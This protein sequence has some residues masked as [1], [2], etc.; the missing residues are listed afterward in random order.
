MMVALII[1][2]LLFVATSVALYFS[3]RRNMQ[4]DDRID[5]FGEQLDQSLDIIDECYGRI[6][7][8][9]ETPLLTDEPV[10]RS[11]MSD[12]K[13]TR[14]AVLLVANKITSFDSTLVDDEVNET[15]DRS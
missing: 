4:I 1:V 14:Q 15:S 2:S 12:I 5:E 3:V 6:S 9:A 7:R 8:A 10:V 11:L 13:I